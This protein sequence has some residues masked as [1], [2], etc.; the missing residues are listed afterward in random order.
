MS[1][2]IRADLENVN[3]EQLA[4]VY[5]LAF[6]GVQTADLIERIFR[7]SYATRIAILDGD[8]VGGVYAFSDGELDASIHGLCVHPD[9]QGHG[10]GRA[11]MESLLETFGP[12]MA[13]LLTAEQAHQ[14][15]Y[16][17]FGFRPLKTAMAKG[18]PPDDMED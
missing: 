9:F 11:L 17:K 12:H 3:W 14:P 13:L 18:F 6:K 4:Q 7:R 8:I 5:A 2:E 10:I 16:R 1:L 15:I